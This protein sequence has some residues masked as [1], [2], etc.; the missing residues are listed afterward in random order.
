MEIQRKQEFIVNALYFAI[1][2]TLVFVVLK[3][4]FPLL[5][6]FIIGFIIAMAL[7]PLVDYLTKKLKIKRKFISIFFLVLFYGIIGLTIFYISLRMFVEAR[8]LFTALP[9]LYAIEIEPALNNIFLELEET[10]TQLN[11]TLII[12]IQSIGENFL[13]SLGTIVSSISSYSIKLIT[14]LATSIPAALIS[15]LFTIVASFFITIDFHEIIAFLGRQLPDKTREIITAVGDNLFGTL[16]K[17]IKAYAILMSITM[18]ELSIGFSILGLP[19]AIGVAA[20][21]AIIDILPVLGT[22]GVL[23]PWTIIEFA[24][25]RTNFA[26]GLLLVYGVV[27]VVRNILEPKVVGDQIGLYPLLTLMCMYVGGQLF[28]I[29]GL[30]GLPI[31]ATII[32]NLNDKNTIQIIK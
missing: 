7:R 26:I 12:G 1:V 31:A 30:F 27:T 24:N 22:G 8:M 29:V 11:P 14:N 9:E 2:G 25:G 15:F 21:I 28:G 18:I 20:L 19:N 10:I 5:M 16:F 23:I 4:V 3:Y 13:Q 17:F 32:K 6:P